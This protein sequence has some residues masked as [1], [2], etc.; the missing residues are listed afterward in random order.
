[1]KVKIQV[2]VESKN[3]E[4]PIVEELAELSRD[5]LTPETLGLTLDEAK[6]LLANLQSTMVTQQ[7]DQYFEKQ[8][9]CTHC[10]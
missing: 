3:D 9:R 10:G 7:V 1:M 2:I 6:N 4:A 8:R 5:D